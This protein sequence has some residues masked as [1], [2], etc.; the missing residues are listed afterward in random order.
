MDKF[1]EK[2][3]SIGSIS[4]EA[5]RA[6]HESSPRCSFLGKAGIRKKK[7]KEKEKEVFACALAFRSRTLLAP[8]FLHPQI[9]VTI[10]KI[11]YE[12]II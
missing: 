1:N 8:I 7:K 10:Y 6:T 5:R 2:E 12:I 9:T 4:F 3:V 11:A